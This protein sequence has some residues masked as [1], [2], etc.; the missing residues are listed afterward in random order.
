[1]ATTNRETKEIRIAKGTI[2]GRIK[3]DQV[4]PVTLVGDVYVN[5]FRDYDGSWLYSIGR[6]QYCCPG[7]AGID[8]EEAYWRSIGL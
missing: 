2:V 4:T 1:M 5:A 6:Q 7:F 3:G 8:S